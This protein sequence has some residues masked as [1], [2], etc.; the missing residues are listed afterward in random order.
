MLYLKGKS[1]CP[2]WVHWAL[3]GGQKEAHWLWE[4]REMTRNRPKSCK[5]TEN[6]SDIVKIHISSHTFAKCVGSA[7]QHQNEDQ[8]EFQILSSAGLSWVIFTVFLHVRSEH[9]CCS[10]TNYYRLSV[11]CRGAWGPTQEALVDFSF[12][13]LLWKC[14]ET[15]KSLLLNAVF[16]SFTTNDVFYALCRGF[17]N[18]SQKQRSDR[19]RVDESRVLLSAVFLYLV[20]AWTF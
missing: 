18:V 3:G 15:V 14:P 20:T 8:P 13:Q 5:E 16:K 19:W 9:V 12:M 7:L 1:T 10:H 2:G 6:H 4:W 17:D 11:G